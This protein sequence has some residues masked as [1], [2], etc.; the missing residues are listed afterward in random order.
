MANGVT[1]NGYVTIG[2]FEKKLWNI[3]GDFDKTMEKSERECKDAN[4]RIYD[5]SMDMKKNIVDNNKC[6]TDLKSDVTQVKND[7]DWL[8]KFFWIIAASSI[9]ALV[10]GIINLVVK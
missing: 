9:G 4:K 7:V 10:T 5:E 6:I 1:K 8:K 2:T 3:K